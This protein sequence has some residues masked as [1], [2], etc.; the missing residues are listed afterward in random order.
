MGL[1]IKAGPIRRL[2]WA[3]KAG[4]RRETARARNWLLIGSTSLSIAYAPPKPLPVMDAPKRDGV[5]AT[6]LHH[7]KSTLHDPS[8]PRRALH[9][10]Q[11][12]A[13]RAAFRC[14]G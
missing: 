12:R 10:T 14:G 8:S 2:T 4:C 11:G 7:F 6:P 3:R 1:V 13:L 9:G 5:P